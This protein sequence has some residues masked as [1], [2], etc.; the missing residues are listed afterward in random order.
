MIRLLGEYGQMCVKRLLT[1]INYGSLQ[2]IFLQCLIG[3]IYVWVNS[4]SC[5]HLWSTPLDWVTKCR[6]SNSLCRSY[7]PIRSDTIQSAVHKDFHSPYVNKICSSR[8]RTWL[9]LYKE[10]PYRCEV[11][12]VHPVRQPQFLKFCISIIRVCALQWSLECSWFIPRWEHT[13]PI[14]CG[15]NDWLISVKHTCLPYLPCFSRYRS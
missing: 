10:L 3:W 1:C 14:N 4:P 2:D 8:P 12:S 6:K 11:L 9:T 13:W 7:Q 5:Y 15:Y